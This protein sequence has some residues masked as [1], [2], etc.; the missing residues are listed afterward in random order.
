MN[1]SLLQR[2]LTSLLL[3]CVFSGIRPIHAQTTDYTALS[4]EGRT[5][6]WAG[7]Y[8]KAETLLR[9]ALE[10]AQHIRD[11]YAVAA[12]YGDL[13]AVYQNQERLMEAEQSYEKRSPFQANPKYEL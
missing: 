12:A 7:H 6:Y 9:N 4:G 13:G 10:V 5:E 1:E 2:Y 11:E 3:L 8:E